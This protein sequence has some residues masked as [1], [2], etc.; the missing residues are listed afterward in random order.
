MMP[1]E[2]TFNTDKKELVELQAG[3]VDVMLPGEQEWQTFSTGQSFTVQAHASFD[4]K[5]HELTDYCC[6][7]IDS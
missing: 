3:M 1:G 2:Y 4:I 6:S 5:V 7:Y